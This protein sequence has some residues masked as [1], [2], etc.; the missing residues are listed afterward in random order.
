MHFEKCRV[1]VNHII[2]WRQCI[3]WW[4]CWNVDLLPQVKNLSTHF[5]TQSPHPI[6]TMGPSTEPKYGLAYHFR[7]ERM[8]EHKS[9]YLQFVDAPT[10]SRNLS[11]TETKIK[12]SFHETKKCENWIMATSSRTMKSGSCTQKL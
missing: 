1:H 8:N 5:Q 7:D 4:V 2:V 3:N 11:R 6:P 9:A 12:R 10:I